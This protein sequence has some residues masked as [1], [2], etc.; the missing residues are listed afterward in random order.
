VASHPRPPTSSLDV[1]AIL[2]TAQ[3]SRSER[4]GVYAWYVLGVLFLVYVLN[5]IDRSIL[6]ILA[7]DIKTDLRLGDQQL[8]F[9]YGTAFAVFYGL[10]GIP[11]GRLA[12]SWYR[13]RLIAAG[14]GVWSAMTALSGI[15]GSYGQLALARIG[16]GIG[17]AS[18]SPAAYSL[19]ADYFPVRRRALVLS[20]YTSGMYVGRGL[21]LPLGG[22]IAHAWNRS[23]AHGTAP[24]GLAG[25]QVAF[26]AVGVP[27]LLLGLWVL[28]LREP[29]RGLAEGHPSP[30]VRPGA[31]RAFGRELMAILPP[32]TVWSVARFPGAL[33][34]NLLLLGAIAGAAVCL[35]RLTGD[36]LQWGT[37][38]LGA[39]AVTSWTQM[40][41][42]TDR[43]TFALLF[44]T[45]AIVLALCGFGAIGYVSYSLFWAPSYAIRTFG[46]GADVAGLVLGVPG[47]FASAAGCVTGGHLSDL[48]KRRDPRGRRFV[49][50]LAAILPAPLL[51]AALA[52]ADVRV[53]CLIYPLIMFVAY[54]WVGPAV[55]AIQDCVLPRMRGTAGAIF[56]LAVSI[57]GLGLGPYCTGKIAALTGSL[58]TGM[59][60]MIVFMPLALLLLWLASG[61]IGAAEDTRVARARAAG[62]A[63]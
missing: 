63:S 28:T 12:D 29:A 32:F 56:L 42:A 46:V 15:A 39:Y 54:L 59:L 53:F 20:I 23:Y 22:W 8:G 31:W 24:F 30:A 52:A 27:G 17:E 3:L 2:A 62:E 35:A 7:Q 41:Y 37:I 47:A 44:G 55:A 51:F 34:G 18:A 45:R 61:H 11:L 49:C 14:L 50:M 19:L 6:S 4:T 10:F 21:S 58:R 5:F 43:P 60:S 13:G 26:L 33:R 16:V 9:L 57:L 40:L 25:W 38:G 48:W 36:T 1:T